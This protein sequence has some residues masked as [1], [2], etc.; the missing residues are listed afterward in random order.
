MWLLSLTLKEE[1]VVTIIDNYAD[2][3][4]WTQKG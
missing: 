2:D 4:F 1:Q 3:N